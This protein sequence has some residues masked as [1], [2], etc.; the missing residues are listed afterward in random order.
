MY[1]PRFSGSHY[2]MG[3]T[4]GTRLCKN[5]IDLKEFIHMDEF[6]QSHG[7]KSHVILLKFFP[8]VCQEIRGLADGLEYPYEQ[9]V[10]WLLCMGCCYDP[11]GC[12]TFCFIHNGNVFFGRNNDLPPFLKK[13]S[14]SILYKPDGG[15]AFIGNTSS[16]INLEEGLNQCG[17]A[18]GMEFLMPTIIKDGFNSVFIVRYLLEKCDSTAA[19]LTTLEQIPVASACSIILADRSGAMAV[20]ECSPERRVVRKPISKGNFLVSTNHFVS[21][22]MR[23]LNS[24]SLHSSQQRYRTAV[25]ALK[26]N[27]E[28]NGCQLAMEILRGEHGFMCQYH[29]SINFETIWSSVFDVSNMKVYRAEGDPSK[30]KFTEDGRSRYL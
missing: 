23:A 12:S 7:R 3:L 22:E 29:P 2:N 25:N 13:S 26:N 27:L 24:S 9:L 16:M 1:H 28:K 10:A 8:E 20:V 30:V 19:A 21:T 18:V 5:G 17:L 6:Q 15:Y 11:R 4:M 14:Q